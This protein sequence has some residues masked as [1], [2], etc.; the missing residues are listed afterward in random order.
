M[1]A[2][3]LIDAHVHLWD[4]QRFRMSWLDGEAKLNRRYGLAE[5]REHTA[6]IEIEALVYVEVGVEPHYALMEARWAAERARE[7]SR[8]RGIVAAAPLEYGEQ[9]RAYLEA[10]K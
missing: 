5:Y 10:L 7:D 9:V 3:P 8:I 1:P 4:P 6:G 2:F